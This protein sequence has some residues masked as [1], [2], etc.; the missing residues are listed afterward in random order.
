MIQLTKDKLAKINA[1]VI[2]T[3]SIVVARLQVVF[4]IIIESLSWL[5]N[6]PNTSAALQAIVNPKYVPFMFLALGMLTELAH[7]RNRKN[8]EESADVER[9]A[10]IRPQS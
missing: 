7:R 2:F 10:G 4:W 3:V 1:D 9:Y 6:D 8:Q 5:S